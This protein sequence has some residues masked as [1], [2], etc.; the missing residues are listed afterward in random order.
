MRDALFWHYYWGSSCFHN[1]HYIFLGHKSHSFIAFLLMFY[2]YP[3][4]LVLIIIP[5]IT[6]LIWHGLAY[7][8]PFFGPCLKGFLWWRWW[9]RFRQLKSSA[10]HPKSEAVH[11]P[12]GFFLSHPL[13][14]LLNGQIESSWT[15]FPMTSTSRHYRFFQRYTIIAR[16][17]STSS[18]TRSIYFLPSLFLTFC[19]CIL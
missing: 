8:F 11:Y 13:L 19:C 2:A 16:H 3:S 15:Q 1:N 17:I 9:W 12:S 7:R 4:T 6:L 14:V 10:D 5:I 18:V